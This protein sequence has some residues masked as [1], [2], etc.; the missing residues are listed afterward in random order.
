MTY[1]LNKYPNVSENVLYLSI[2]I[3]TVVLI[4][5][6]IQI[7]MCVESTRVFQYKWD[8]WHPILV[9]TNIAQFTF[10][11]IDANGGY[12]RPS[13]RPSTITSGGGIG[14]GNGNGGSGATVGG[15]IGVIG[16]G[17]SQILPGGGGRIGNH[18]ILRR[19]NGMWLRPRTSW[20]V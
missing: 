18:R 12:K 15:C 5:T 7:I 10:R 6:V 4:V 13:K 8:S 14:I 19:K 3:P 9:F 11:L 1:V 20:G 16:D 17:V 2:R